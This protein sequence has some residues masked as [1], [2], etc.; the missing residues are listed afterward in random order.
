MKNMKDIEFN[1]EFAEKEDVCS[2]CGGD[3]K[4]TGWNEEKAL[5]RFECA[6]CGSVIVYDSNCNETI[7]KGEKRDWAT[8]LASRLSFPFKAQV[9]DSQ[10][11][12]F[13]NGEKV[14]VKKIAMDDDLFGVIVDIYKGRKKYALPLCELAAEDPNSANYGEVNRYRTWFVNCRYL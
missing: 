12:P 6:D 3:S 4:Q 11:G 14:V 9:G 8:Y 10:E 5:R 1:G 7:L 13:R 2:I